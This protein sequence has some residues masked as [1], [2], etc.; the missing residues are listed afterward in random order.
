MNKKNE[1]E[2]I[3]N[4]LAIRCQLGD[5]DA[6]NE[7]VERWNPRLTRFLSRMINDSAVVEDLTQTIWLKIVRSISQLKEPRSLAAWIYRIAR[8]AVTDRLRRQYRSPIAVDEETEPATHDLAM[9]RFIESDHL[10]DALHKLHPQDREV[11]VLHYFE[12]LSM[13]EV[14]GVCGVPVGTAKSRMNRARKSLRQSLDSGNQ[15]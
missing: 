9:E 5:H 2:T 7:L 8:T 13:T 11:L 10:A 14:A 3:D 1:D 12:H 15:S 6:W 4:R